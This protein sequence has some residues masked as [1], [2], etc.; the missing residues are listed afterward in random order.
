MRFLEIN[1]SHF[2]KI[3]DRYFNLHNSSE[4]KCQK[5]LINL[6]INDYVIP[7]RHLPSMKDEM[8]VVLQGLC[9]LVIFNNHGEIIDGILIGSEKYKKKTN[10]TYG[11]QIKPNYWHTLISITKNSL[12]L[13]IKDGP[14]RK[15]TNKELPNWFS[16]DIHDKRNIY[17]NKV[18]SL[19]KTKEKN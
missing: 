9:A 7:H 2:K 1:S 15:K 8:I 14:F 10:S 17:I 13:E 3:N 4:C 16:E 18:L 12:L 19:I 6:S 5:I 11:Y